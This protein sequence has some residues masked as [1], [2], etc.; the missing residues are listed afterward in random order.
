VPGE[1]KTLWNMGLETYFNET[2]SGERQ[3]GERQDKN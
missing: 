2:T 1:L 3:F